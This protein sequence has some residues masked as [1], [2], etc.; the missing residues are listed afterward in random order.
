MDAT[1]LKK[2][3]F[4]ALLA[5]PVI[6]GIFLF[7]P[8]GTLDYWQAWVY[9]AI[10][11][12]PAS[13]V[14]LYFLKKDPAFLERRMRTKESEARQ[15]LIIK[16]SALM[17]IIAFL[18]PGFDYRFGWSLVP[19]EI[20]IVADVFVFLGYL[21]IFLVFRENGYAGRTVQVDKGQRVISTGPYSVVRHPM[22]VGTLVMYMATPIAL[23]SYVAVPAFILLIPVIVLRILNEEEVLRRDLPGY[24]EYCRKTRYRLIPF[25]W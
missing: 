8:A 7:G 6:L 21:L 14:V 11:V 25:I 18:I 9:I 17:F 20:S 1:A 4:L 24:V 13:F 3:I 5:T 15:G 22:Y 16:V 10:L 12:V 2:K 23:G 19:H